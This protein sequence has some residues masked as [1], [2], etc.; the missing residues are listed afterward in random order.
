MHVGGADAGRLH[1][2]C[3]RP[4]AWRSQR[5]ACQWGISWGA[6]GGTVEVDALA[7]LVMRKLHPGLCKFNIGQV[8][9]KQ[10]W[11][12]RHGSFP[13]RYKKGLEFDQCWYS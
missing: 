2:T 13:F 11:K 4:A 7:E 10:Q 3:W 12:S 9:L 5:G 8:I 6:I 1:E